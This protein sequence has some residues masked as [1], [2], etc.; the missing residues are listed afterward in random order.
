[1]PLLGK[2]LS[3]NSGS[4]SSMK[5]IKDESLNLVEL[6]SVCPLRLSATERHLL[7][8]LEQAMS[9]SEYTDVVDCVSRRGSNVKTRR[10][11]DGILEVCHIAT[12]LASASGQ[13]RQLATLCCAETEQLLRPAVFPKLTQKKKKKK[14][15]ISSKFKKG[16]K[17]KVT[18]APP[19]EGGSCAARE[20]ADNEAFYQTLFEV[21]RRNKI[22][23]PASMRTTYGKLMYLLQDAQNPSVAKSLGF[24]LHKEIML[25]KPFLEERGGL[26]LLHDA[27]LEC[28]VQFISDRD[29]DTGEKLPREQVQAIVAGK[30][31]VTGDL[32]QAYAKDSITEDDVKRVIE[33][34]ADAIAYIESNKCSNIWKTVSI[35]S[36]KERGSPSLCAARGVPTRVLPISLPTVCRPMAAPVP[37]V[38]PY[39]IPTRHST[40][41]FGNLSACGAR[42]CE[43]CINSTTVQM[44]IS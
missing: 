25:V 7:S 19:S 16:R 24:S 23:N 28:A 30:H 38:Q 32:V 1:M 31:K 8:V 18:A 12:G 9:V 33:S 39:H 44:R 21:G 35:R 20:P 43:T 27:R 2:S 14:S 34:L 6:A 17:Q 5:D 4:L 40:P 13:E 29:A 41:L 36:V 37:M 10:I 3:G 42:S 22:L 15:T 11:L 26:D